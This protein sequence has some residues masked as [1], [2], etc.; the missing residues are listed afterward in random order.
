RRD[1]E[2][3]TALLLA[4]LA[5]LGAAA[6]AAP[7]LVLDEQFHQAELTAHLDVLD[8]DGS[9]VPVP[10][11]LA[12]QFHPLNAGDL[13]PSARTFWLRFGAIN[14]RPVPQTL[15]LQVRPPPDAKAVAA[16]SNNNAAALLPLAHSRHDPLAGLFEV[17][18]PPRSSAMFYLR[19]GGNPLAPGSLQLFTLDRFLVLSDLQSWLGGGVLGLLLM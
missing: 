5:L 4:W 12:A 18:V 16:L 6:H 13:G 11:D 1:T 10:Q 17:R 2:W 19:S 14:P 9:H 8:A 7:A 3:L 15:I